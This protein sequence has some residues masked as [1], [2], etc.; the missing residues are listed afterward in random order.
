VL[1]IAVELI[2]L[3]II[4]LNVKML[5][6]NAVMLSDIYASITVELIMLN[7][8]ILN[9]KMLSAKCCYAE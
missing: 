1:S 5:S 9:V 2:T 3:S 4:I 7:F 8:V 6:A